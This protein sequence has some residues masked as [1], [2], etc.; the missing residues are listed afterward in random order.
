MRHLLKILLVSAL[1][2]WSSG[3][4]AE[5]S[6]GVPI[7]DTA[8]IE[9]SAELGPYELHYSLFPST[10][11]SETVAGAYG[12][13]RATNRAVINVSLRE[14]LG[15]GTTR[16]QSA[17]VKGSY[18]DLIQKKPLEFREVR[19]QGA[20]YYIAE[21]RH[22]NRETLRFDLVVTPPGGPEKRITFTR[23]LYVD[24]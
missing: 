10:F 14:K 19:E 3:A 23:K 7:A 5:N 6:S 9:T 15:D 13:T 12:I 17:Q 22:S 16:E 2:L 1:P 11:L 20:I 18:S 24:E 21:F 8:P 4:P